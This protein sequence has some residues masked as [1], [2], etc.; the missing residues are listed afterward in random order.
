[1]LKNETKRLYQNIPDIKMPLFIKGGFPLV[2]GL[3]FLNLLFYVAA[4]ALSDKVLFVALRSLRFLSSFLIVLSLTAIM[5]T[6]YRTIKHFYLRYVL[7]MVL[8]LLGGLCGVILLVFD[9]FIIA[10]AGGYG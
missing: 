1:M 10:T 5:Y 7:Y 8:Y 2:F 9:T 4:G 6:V 3:S